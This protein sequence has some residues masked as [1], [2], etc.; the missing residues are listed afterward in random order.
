MNYMKAEQQDNR[1][2]EMLMQN[3]AAAIPQILAEANRLESGECVRGVIRWNMGLIENPSKKPITLK[4]MKLIRKSMGSHSCVFQA[5]P[6]KPLE[7][8]F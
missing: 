6:G 1:R 2:T 5:E 3:I 7:L 4:D 8:L